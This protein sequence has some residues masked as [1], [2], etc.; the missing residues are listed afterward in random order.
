MRTSILKA[1][2]KNLNVKDLEVLNDN[3]LRILEV[4]P[5]GVIVEGRE[6]DIIDAFFEIKNDNII[7][8]IN[9]EWNL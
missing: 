9:K 6:Q 5:Y 2:F 7:I 8:S 3:P 1:R 4:K